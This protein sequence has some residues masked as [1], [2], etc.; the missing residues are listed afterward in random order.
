MLILA[1]Q[2]IDFYLI[3]WQNKTEYVYF[4][5]KNTQ[6]INLICIME[7]RIRMS[8]VLEGLQPERVFYYF[9]EL[10]RIPHG[11]RNTKAISDYCVEFA[12]ERDLKY[13][14]DEYNNVVIYKPAYAGYEN[15]P[16]VMLQ[17]HLD[18][19]CEKVSDSKHDF[20]KD[21]LDI[22]IDG[23][24]ITARGTT[25]GGDDGVAVAY[26]LAILDD[27]SIKA[28]AIEAV[29]TV[30]EEIGL[31]GAK[32]LDASVLSAK[33]MINIDNEEEGTFI[34]G[35]AGGMRSGLKLPVEYTPMKGNEYKITIT[36]L[37]GGH[38][39]V[40]INKGRANAHIIL[41]RLLF[42]LN[43]ELFYGISALTGG[44]MDNAITRECSVNICLDKEDEAVLN[45]ICKELEAQLKAEYS[46]TDE[47]ITIKLEDLGEFDELVIS[48]KAKQIFTFILMNVPN[49]I[50]K[51]SGHIN[52]LVETSLNLGILSMDDEAITISFSVRSSVGSAKQA[53][54]DKL[55][56][57]IEFFG[58][59]YIETGKYPEWSYRPQSPFRDKA[60]KLYEDMFNEKANVCVIHAGLEC[61]L[62][63]EKLPQLDMISIGPNMKDIHTPEECLSIK[64]TIKIW[65][66]LIALLES[67]N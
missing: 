14:Q 17:G 64:S 35:C 49:G 48:E 27:T 45:T 44:R 56:Y 58:G 47:G 53:L 11:S 43:E 10:T 1:L 25:L 20:E 55:R 5:V 38:S 29:F 28:P 7:M 34:V 50:Q 62:F 33:Y 2:S 60:V 21:A 26:M 67:M 32:A 36:G 31:D 15:A 4:F 12:K 22:Y 39:G 18:M 66:Y 3:L 54:A 9:E 63:A 6:A 52:G 30:D 8:R 19:V 41:G 46:G 42:N 16:A 40:E 65:N 13:Y 61:G 51:M 37:L 59:E 24:Y 23:D 57:M